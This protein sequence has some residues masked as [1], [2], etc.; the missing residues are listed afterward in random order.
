MFLFLFLH[1]LLLPCYF[2]YIL[3]CLHWNFFACFFCFC[4]YML[5]CLHINLLPCYFVYM[6]FCLQFILFICSFVCLLFC[7]DD[8][9]TIKLSSGNNIQTLVFR[10]Q[11]WLLSWWTYGSGI[12]NYLYNQCLS[13]T[14]CSPTQ[15]PQLLSENKSLNVVAWTKFY[16]FT[17]I[18]AK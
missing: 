9:K 15:Q 3:F 12:E 4:L 16:C 14:I 5:F 2:V 7:Y 13:T 11:L 17:I 8:G 10:Q 6:F 1:V 18:V